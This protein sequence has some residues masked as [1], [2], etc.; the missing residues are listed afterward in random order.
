MVLICVSLRTNSAEHLCMC[1][2]ISLVKCL[3]GSLASCFI[4]SFI[5]LL[6]NFE[7]LLCILDT[8][9]LSS[10][11]FADNFSQSVTCFLI[12]AVSFGG[13]KFLIFALFS[14]GIFGFILSSFS[15]LLPVM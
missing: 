1:L 9:Y 15:D 12:L 2:C 6:M 5:Y 14:I 11:W 4:G 3:L 7:S 8:S 13:Q 10:V